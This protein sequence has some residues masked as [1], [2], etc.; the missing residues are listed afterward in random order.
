MIPEWITV[1]IRSPVEGLRVAGVGLSDPA[2]SPGVGR[3]RYVRPQR[4]HQI[5][6]SVH[7]D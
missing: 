2:K 7:V 4:S 1:E 3:E 6:E 5:E